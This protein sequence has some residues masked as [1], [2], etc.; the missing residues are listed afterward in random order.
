MSQKTLAVLLSTLVFS[1]PAFPQPFSWNLSRDVMTPSVP[2]TT[3][4][5]LNPTV[6]TPPANGAWSFAKLQSG[7]YSLLPSY[8]PLCGGAT[9]TPPTL[10]CWEDA[11]GV[12]PLIAASPTNTVNENNGFSNFDL[13]QG[14]TQIHPSNTARVVVSWRSP[15]AGSVRILGRIADIDAACGDGVR[16]R[17]RK[18]PPGPFP[19]PVGSTVAVPFTSVPNVPIIVNP[20]NPDKAFTVASTPVV[21]GTEILF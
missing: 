2:P 4:L 15:V 17:I 21:V 3:Y 10:V 14:M 16:L 9:V 1:S 11:R 18:A 6:P 13:I 19:F 7:T 12:L 8:N 20:G 5:S